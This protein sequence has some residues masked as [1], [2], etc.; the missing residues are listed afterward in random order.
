MEIPRDPKLASVLTPLRILT[1]VGPPHAFLR[2]YADV[3][4]ETPDTIVDNTPRP[5]LSSLNPTTSVKAR[6]TVSERKLPARETAEENLP[7]RSDIARLH[8]LA[9]KDAMLSTAAPRA[10]KNPSVGRP[11]DPVTSSTKA[12]MNPGI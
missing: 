4:N 10:Q 3:N 8:K 11:L 5:Y 2:E 7:V 9:K 1:S 12:C 6:A